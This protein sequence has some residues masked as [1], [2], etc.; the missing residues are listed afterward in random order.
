MDCAPQT[1]ET[2]RFDG[3]DLKKVEQFKNLGS[4][5][6]SDSDSFQMS[7]PMSVPLGW[8]GPRWLESCVMPLCLKSKIYITIMHPVALYKLEC[9]SVTAKHDAHGMEIQSLQRYLGLMQFNH[10]M[11]DDIWCWLGVTPIVAKMREERHGR[12]KEDSVARTAMRLDPDAK[13]RWMVNGSNQG[14]HEMHGWHPWRCPG[15]I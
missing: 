14:G 4:F 11:N 2:I 5:I 6:C 7:T 15:S 9:W 1:D 8:S 12:S 10:I 3:E 13:N